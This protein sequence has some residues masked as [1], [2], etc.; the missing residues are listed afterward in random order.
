MASAKH[1]RKTGK[2]VEEN[3]FRRVHSAVRRV[4][5]G[6]VATYGDIARE[7]GNAKAARQVA[8]ALRHAP[9]GLPWFRIVGAG[10]KIRLPGASGL[11]QRRRLEAE[12]VAFRGSSVDLTRHH[13]FPG[14]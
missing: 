2:P 6:A 10:G 7:A 1:L 5:R 12:G 14:Q 9:P 11:E 3:W 8:W 4:P 13:A